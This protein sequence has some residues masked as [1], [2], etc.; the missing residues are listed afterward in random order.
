[1]EHALKD[2]GLSLLC[3]RLG[4]CCDS[5]SGSAGT[6]SGSLS[7]VFSSLIDSAEMLISL[8]TA[9]ELLAAFCTSLSASTTRSVFALQPQSNPTANTAAIDNTFI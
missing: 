3:G 5:V 6:L 7:V 2:A 1:M 4:S 8:C 9:T